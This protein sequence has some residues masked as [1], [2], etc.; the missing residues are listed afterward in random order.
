MA[1]P[2]VGPTA[3]GDAAEAA[4]P[5]RRAR[6]ATRV[7]FAVL[8]GLAG[9]WGAHIPAVQA[10]GGLSAA[11]LAGVLLAAGLGSVLSLLF[12]GRVLARLGARRM[13]LLGVVAMGVSLALL[14]V[15]GAGLPGLLALG[16]V[17]G[18]GMSLFDVAINT[19]G[20]V[21]EHLGRRA[22]MSNL[23]AMFS[24][25]G[26][27]GAATVA[28]LL[29]L[30]VPAAVQ[31]AALGLAAV[32]VSAAATRGMLASHAGADGDAG[33]A[34]GADIAPRAHFAWPRGTLLLIGL[35]ILAGMLAEGVMYDW[36]VLYLQQVTGLAQADA[37]LGYAAFAG[38]MAAARFAGDALR[39]R[40]PERHLL[41]GGG[42]LAAGAMAV[43]LWVGHPGVALAGFVLVGI[44]LAPVAP[45]LFN[46]ATRVPGVSR[47]AAIAAVTSIGYSG[48]LLGPPLV[49]ALAQWVSLTAALGVV[50]VAAAALALGA[51]R[52]PAGGGTG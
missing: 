10:Q 26:M 25:G 41:A 17:L 20:S 14:L 18:V 45:I 24:V 21:L 28:A 51:Q 11:A 15:Q 52:V 31:L 50:V 40:F 36:C 48:F 34:A 35:L 1:E 32:G 19:E 38:A 23:H 6:W 13:V 3:E 5:L 46:A 9:T 43:V 27:L 16:L 8:G 29:R 30:G 49:G 33:A 12:A 42:A 4:P 7:Q 37:A 22:V 2:S 47:V 44:G 39:E